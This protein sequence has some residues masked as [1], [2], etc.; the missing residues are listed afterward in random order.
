MVSRMA[1]QKDTRPKAKPTPVRFTP[2]ILVEV[3]AVA[4][5]LA[6]S[7]QDVIRLAVSAGLV[8]AGLKALRSLGR[9]GLIE[10]IA[11]ELD[12]RPADVED[13]PRAAEDSIRY[14]TPPHDSDNE[15][16]TP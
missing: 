14:G 7:R 15:P 3:D 16:R 10:R 2:E 13:F 9:E 6:M 8:S 11:E 12:G 1:R 4:E 5:D